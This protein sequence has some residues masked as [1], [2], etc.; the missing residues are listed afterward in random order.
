MG[1]HA[2]G[3]SKVLLAYAPR[4]RRMVLDYAGRISR[5]LR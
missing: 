5:S 4:H 1:P 3:G 2:G